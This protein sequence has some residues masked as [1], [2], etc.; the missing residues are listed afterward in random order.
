MA[1]AGLP[2]IGRVVA[3]FGFTRKK[4]WP[5]MISLVAMMAIG[6]IRVWTHGLE[7]EWGLAFLLILLPGFALVMLVGELRLVGPILLIGEKGLLDR[8]R[9]PVPVAWP[10][11]QEATVRRRALTQGIRIM[12]TNGERYDLE[13]NLLAADAAVVMRHIQEQAARG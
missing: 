8:R 12:L 9:G 1:E 7:N 5:F 6:V 3:S 13:L 4:T 11:I 10:M 2:D